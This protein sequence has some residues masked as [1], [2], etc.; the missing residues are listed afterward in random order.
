MSR[1]VDAIII[2]GGLAGANLAL[3]FLNKGIS[4]AVFDKEDLESA[5]Y[6]A[7][8]IIN[9]ITGRRFV[10]TWLYDQLKEYFIPYYSTWED[11]WQVSFFN[12]V[13]IFRSIPDNKLVN[14]LDAK[15]ADPDYAMYCR[16]MEASEGEFLRQKINFQLPGYVFFGYQVNT[17]IFLENARDYITENAFWIN[18]KISLDSVN[19]TNGKYK[20]KDFYSKRLI[21]ACGA[22][23]L[24]SSWFNWAGLNPN[25]GEVLKITSNIPQ[26]SDLIKQKIF[27][28]PESQNQYWVGSYS[29][30]APSTEKA[31]EEGKNYLIRHLKNLIGLDYRIDNHLAAFRPAITDRRPVIGEHP[32][33][34]GLYAFN[35]F[36]SKGTSLIPYF[37][38]HFYNY[39]FEGKPLAEEVDVARYWS[40]N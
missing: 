37:A 32:Q 4:C 29:T 21:L 11:R 3:S 15:L 18:D 10:K 38:D 34:N 7:S 27:L 23:A 9:P 31:S 2:G 26:L 16:P 40:S 12:E 30:W 24:D 35:G 39:L 14:D 22:Q 28:V 13:N 25:R 1:E 5:S 20:I 36:G 8:G 19:S 6:V 33:K 17:S